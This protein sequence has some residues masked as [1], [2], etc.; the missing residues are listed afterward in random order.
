MDYD[1][2]LGQKVLNTLDDRANTWQRGELLRLL[3]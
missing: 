2:S 3:R 1:N